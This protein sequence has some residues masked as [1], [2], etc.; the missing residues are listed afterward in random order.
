MRRFVP[1]ILVA[2]ALAGCGEAP[3]ISA[4]A[5]VLPTAP[6]DFGKPVAVKPP[7]IGEDARAYAARERAARL[8]ANRRLTNDAAFYADV[9]SKFGMPAAR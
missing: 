7:K 5:P 9:V 3:V 1:G 8:T 2:L 6:T 4:P